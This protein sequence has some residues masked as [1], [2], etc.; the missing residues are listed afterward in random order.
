[1]SRRAPRAPACGRGSPPAGRCRAGGPA[2]ATT[3]ASSL[4]RRSR[5]CLKRAPKTARRWWRGARLPR[6]GSAARR[7]S[8]G[9]PGPAVSPARGAADEPARAGL[10]ANLARGLAGLKHS[11]IPQAEVAAALK[12]VV[13]GVADTP[14]E[15]RLVGAGTKAD[16]VLVG[17]IDPGASPAATRVEL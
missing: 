14:E 8:S 12:S 13:D 1:P 2:S 4:G 7:P 16:W 11:A 9:R 6:R 15:Y 3:Q 10:D 17:T 5:R